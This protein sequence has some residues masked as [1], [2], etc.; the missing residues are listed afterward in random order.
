[1]TADA[2]VWA[3]TMVKD[4]VDVIEGVLRHLDG[5][6]LNG[7]IVCDNGSTDGTRD[8]LH[9]LASDMETPLTVIVDSDPAYDQSAK[10]TRLAARARLGAATDDLW[11]IPF[12]ADELWLADDRLGVII[13]RWSAANFR[14]GLGIPAA[15]ADHVPTSVDDPNEPDPFRRLTWRRPQG[16]AHLWKV[17]FRWSPTATINQGNHSVTYTTNGATLR[18]PAETWGG[19]QQLTI[20]HFPYRSLQ[21][22]QRKVRNGAAAYR[23]LGDDRNPQHGIHWLTWD[24]LDD[25]Q[26]AEVWYRY[27][28]SLSPIDDGLTL[29]PAPYRRWETP[30]LG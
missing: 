29:D 7:I 24:R 28:C 6:A 10:M 20:R 13:R 18:E 3:I 16:P 21:Q 2:R 8:I 5:E 19:H 4:E 1:M 30:T 11:I 9:D 23:A 17:A 14:P 26:L 22:F 12:D 27:R 25:E 15:I